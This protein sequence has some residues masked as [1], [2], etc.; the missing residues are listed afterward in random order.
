VY[1]AATA[2]ERGPGVR[3]HAAVVLYSRDLEHWES[4]GR[5]EHDRLPLGLF[6]FGVAGFADGDH[7]STAFPMFFE[8][9][10]G[11]DGKAWLC[12]IEDGQ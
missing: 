1:L 11:L 5:F 6:K 9:L 10:R 7:S 4:V 8:A 3:E 12:A 2:F